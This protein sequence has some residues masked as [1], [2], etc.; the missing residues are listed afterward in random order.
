VIALN[1]VALGGEDH[2]RMPACPSENVQHIQPVERVLDRVIIPGEVGDH[3]VEPQ[4]VADRV[5]HRRLI[6]SNAYRRVT[7]R[8]LQKWFND[9]SQCSS[10]QN[11][12]A[13]RH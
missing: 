6:L 7:H 2:G 8:L 12:W 4:T 9:L 11:T 3:H 5:L 13:V 1:S 10:N